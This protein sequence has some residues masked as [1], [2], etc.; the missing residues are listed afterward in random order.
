MTA[1]DDGAGP[2]PDPT[3]AQGALVAE[4]AS[5]RQQVALL[6]ERIGDM[7]A[8]AGLRATSQLSGGPGE[9]ES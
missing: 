8:S 1:G 3:T 9:D 5:L 4:V 2:A 6:A 7:G